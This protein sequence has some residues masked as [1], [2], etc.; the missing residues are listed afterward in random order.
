M[1]RVAIDTGGTFTDCVTLQDG[2]LRA[3]SMT[4]H[5][6]EDTS[7][8]GRQVR[9]RRCDWFQPAPHSRVPA[10]LRLGINE[11]TRAEGGVLLLPETRGRKL[12]ELDL[13]S[14]E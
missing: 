9:P 5:G 6:F 12:E 13:V 14:G 3:T 7:T 10:E 1:K 11:R 8:I 4:T 2:K